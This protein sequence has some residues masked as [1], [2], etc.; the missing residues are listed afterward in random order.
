MTNDVFTEDYLLGRR[1]LS[2]GGITVT[3]DHDLYR[4]PLLFKRWSLTFRWSRTEDKYHEDYSLHEKCVK[5]DAC[6]TFFC[7][8]STA[9]TEFDAYLF[10]PVFVS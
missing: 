5:F 3:A 2:L 9:L 10:E 6:T 8:P 1:D 4:K 7:F